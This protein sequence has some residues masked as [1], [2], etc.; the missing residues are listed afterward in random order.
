MMPL[1]DTLPIVHLSKDILQ[2]DR[3]SPRNEQQSQLIIDNIS[4]EDVI[5]VWLGRNESSLR[6]SLI[7]Y[8]P[9]QNVTLILFSRKEQ[10]YSWLNS[11]SSLTVACLII[12]TNENLEDLICRCNT[13]SSIR[14]ILIRCFSNELNY[15]RRLFRSYVKI[16]GIFADDT[17]LSIKLLIDLALF[18]EEIADHQA[19]NENKQIYVQKNYDRALNLCA[20]AKRL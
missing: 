3:L 15:F 8:L 1:V 18:S 11:N 10:L 19:D 14:S 5:V 2:I 17:R 20:L 16:N 6:R 12:E 7:E 9:S 13:Y 4:L